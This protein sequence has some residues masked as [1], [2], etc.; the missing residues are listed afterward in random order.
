MIGM[1]SRPTRMPLRSFRDLEVYKRSQ[2]ATREVHGLG[3]EFPEHERFGLTE[4][5][6]RHRS[7]LAH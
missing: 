6:R 2:A 1:E 5:M 4:Q 3:V 7:R